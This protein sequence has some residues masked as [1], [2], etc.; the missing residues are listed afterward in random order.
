MD[1]INTISVEQAASFIVQGDPNRPGPVRLLTHAKPDGD[2]L[3]S[4]LA[5]TYALQQRAVEVEVVFVPPVPDALAAL[6]A[7]GV[8]SLYDP[9]QTYAEPSRVILL[10]TG[11]WQQLGPAR[12]LIEPFLDHALI[13]DHHLSGDIPAKHRFLDPT[14]AATAELLTPLLDAIDA[15]RPHPQGPIGSDAAALLFTAL[16]SDTGWFKFSNTTARTHRLA[17]RL[18]ELGVDHARLYGKLE[19][20]ERPAKLRLMARAMANLELTADDQACL[21]PLA[22]A[23]FEAAG[24]R[25]DETERLVDLPQVVA[26]V[27]V[28]VLLS[29]RMDSEGQVLTSLSFRSKPGSRA[30]DVAALANHFGGGG[31]ARAAG[32]KLRGPLHDHLAKVRSAV[33]EAL[34]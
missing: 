10:D 34:R 29:E 11:A 5:L 9:N 22:R 13:I 4:T 14:A 17:A 32:A 27:R 3:G 33:I 20:T 24:A 15:L 31:H 30:V 7:R 16:A 6:D 25:D 12:V 2:A 8:L 28:V 19:Q 21:I 1:Y 23:D 18:I 26:G